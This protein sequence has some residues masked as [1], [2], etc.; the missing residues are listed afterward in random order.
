M[1]DSYP[2]EDMESMYDKRKELGA[3]DDLLN[4]F[5]SVMIIDSKDSEDYMEKIEIILR[6]INTRA[7]VSLLCTNQILRDYV[8]EQ[9]STDGSEDL[10][11]ETFDPWTIKGLERNAVVLLVLTLQPN[12]ILILEYCGMRTSKEMLMNHRLEPSNS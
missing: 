9:M 12:V 1:K 11:V 7:G 3:D 2:I 10:R 6:E 4:E 5:T 8:D